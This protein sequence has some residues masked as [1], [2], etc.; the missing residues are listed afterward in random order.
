MRAAPA[1]AATPSAEPPRP[2]RPRTMRPCPVRIR[3]RAGDDH[4][5]R[6][7]PSPWEHGDVEST[8]RSRTA[9]RRRSRRVEVTS[10]PP[11]SR[12]MTMCRQRVSRGLASLLPEGE[13]AA[14]WACTAHISTSSTSRS[15]PGTESPARPR[16]V[17]TTSGRS[18]PVI[19]QVPQRARRGRRA[20]AAGLA[21]AA[22]VLSGCTQAQQRGF[23]PGPAD[24]QEVT[25]QTER[26]TNLWVG[27]WAVLVLVGL[28]IWGLTIW[29]AIA[30]RRR[31]HD[32]GFPVQLR[33]HVPLELMFT[34]V[35]VVM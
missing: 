13:G 26:I 25:N 21:L 24:G 29:C 9:G 10:A 6:P 34:L 18:S 5:T 8:D 14:L 28:M 22:L 19:P 7:G 30:Y 1:P 16:G 23:M 3:A 20:A 35:P 32:T 11:R 31:K 2:G 17:G 27:S 33:Y 15:R 4:V 12:M